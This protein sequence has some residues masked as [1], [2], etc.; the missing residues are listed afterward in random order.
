MH[1][2]YFA[3]KSLFRHSTPI[4]HLIPKAP[5]VFV[6]SLSMVREGYEDYIR[7]K[8]DE[9]MNSSTAKIRTLHGADGFEVKQWKDV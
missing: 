5:L 2:D 4:H 3:S 1:S 6:V 7:H 9:E 8:S